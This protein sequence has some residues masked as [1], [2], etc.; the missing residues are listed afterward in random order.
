MAS[1]DGNEDVA[2]H[3]QNVRSSFRSFS[4][5]LA[6]IDS[7]STQDRAEYVREDSVTTGTETSL[8]DLTGRIQDQRAES[9]WQWVS[10]QKEPEPA[11][12]LDNASNDPEWLDALD[13]TSNVLLRGPP[14]CL[15]SDE[16]C[17]TLLAVDSGMAS[18]RMLVTFTQ[19][20][21]D[22]LP[23]YQRFLDGGRG[24]MMIISVGDYA[25][26]TRTAAGSFE[27]GRVSVET[28][29]D[30]GNLRRLGMMISK[31]LAEWEGA[32]TDIVVCFHSLEPLLESSD[33]QTAFRF[34]HIL[35][36]RIRAAGARAHYHLEDSEDPGAAML[37]QLFDVQLD[38]DDDGSVSVRH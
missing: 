20:P 11:P 9:K 10:F 37:G 25:R 17:T 14:D 18:N 34:L 6:R 27:S 32:P 15:A 19:S 7:G 16:L 30:A 28:I 24:Q 36:G 38:F 35:Q 22:R 33:L 29:A 4:D 8:A 23:V 26:S 2:P 31:Y 12:S 21:D 13:G 5:L 3:P 1:D